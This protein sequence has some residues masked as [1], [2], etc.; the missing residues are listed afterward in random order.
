MNRIVYN[1]LMRRYAG[2]QV[3]QP[4]DSEKFPPR[5]GLEGPFR[6]ASGLVVY[7]D[8]KEGLYW[9]SLTDMYL[10]HADYDAH[11]ASR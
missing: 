4:I 9:D 3:V 2:Y 1:Y 5:P 7:Y 6:L 11:Q 8:P 10:D